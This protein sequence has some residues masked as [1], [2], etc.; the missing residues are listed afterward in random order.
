MIS[1]GPKILNALMLST[2]LVGSSL[3]PTFSLLVSLH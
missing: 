2:M 3:E 1:S